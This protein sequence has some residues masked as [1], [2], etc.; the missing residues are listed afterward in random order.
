MS[1]FTLLPSGDNRAL[2]AL[3]QTWRFL[4]TVGKI[5]GMLALGVGFAWG[6][7]VLVG[8]AA[9]VLTSDDAAVLRHVA[10]TASSNADFAPRGMVRENPPRELTRQETLEGER[11]EA[12]V[13]FGLGLVVAYLSLFGFAGVYAETVEALGFGW[14]RDRGKP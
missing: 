7:C 11:L 12:L 6:G 8:N 5:L 2:R 1:E 4:R 3:R 9:D 13:H 14:G 10:E